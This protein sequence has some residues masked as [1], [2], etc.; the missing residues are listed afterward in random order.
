MKVDNDFMIRNKNI[1]LLALSVSILL[2]VA[3]ILFLNMLED[4]N[5]ITSELPS[6]LENINIEEVHE[7]EESKENI[8]VPIPQHNNVGKK[9]ETILDKI[10]EK[11]NNCSFT[12]GMRKKGYTVVATAVGNELD[13]F[14]GGYN[15]GIDIIFKLD[16]NNILS[17]EI[18]FDDDNSDAVLKLLL[19]IVT[20]DCIAQL[21]GYDEY[22]FRDASNNE[23]VLNYTL[24]KEGVEIKKF[25]KE[26]GLRVK[27][28]LNSDF[29]FLKK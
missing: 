26:E 3:V 2:L 14:C 8:I 15:V 12:S 6:G 27:V 25:G 18:L 21:K 23:K 16:N 20:I 1:I 29:S 24:K 17:S 7:S 19:S 5:N 10:K 11:F 22:S 28:D 13:V 9:E 4:D